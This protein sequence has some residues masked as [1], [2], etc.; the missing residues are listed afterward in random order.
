MINMCIKGAVFMLHFKY[1]LSSTL[2]SFIFSSNHLIYYA[3]Y[4]NL[5]TGDPLVYKRKS[6]TFL[7]E[8]E[9]CWE[10]AA[11]WS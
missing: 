7:S 8:F 4:L 6:I 1:R 10:D 9:C 3:F 2:N 11:N 5:E